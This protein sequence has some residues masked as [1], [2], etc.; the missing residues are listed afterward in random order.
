MECIKEGEVISFEKRPA[1]ITDKVDAKVIAVDL[2]DPILKRG[3]FLWITQSSGQ[4]RIKVE[5]FL[6]I[7]K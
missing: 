7:F 5:C 1:L 4:S 3:D 6:K 2:S